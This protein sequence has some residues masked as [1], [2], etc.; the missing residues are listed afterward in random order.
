VQESVHFTIGIVAAAL[1]VMIVL[2]FAVRGE[3]R[4]SEEKRRERIERRRTARKRLQRHLGSARL[5]AGSGA[6]QGTPDAGE[7]SSDETAQHNGGP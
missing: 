7:G 6:K 5:E 1:V 4:E 2:Y 3:T